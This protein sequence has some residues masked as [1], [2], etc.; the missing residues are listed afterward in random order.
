MPGSANLTNLTPGMRVNRYGGTSPKSTFL[1]P[2]GD[3]IAVRALAPGSNLSK[4]DT[5]L[6]KKPLQVT[7]SKVLPWFDQPGL[8]TQFDT[9]AGGGGMTINDAVTRGFLE[10]VP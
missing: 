9:M 5:Y 8:G 4:I 6:V 2:E 10:R 7:Q 3:S 1:A